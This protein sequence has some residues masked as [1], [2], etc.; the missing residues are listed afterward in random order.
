MGPQPGQRR[1]LRSPQS[2]FE[3][4]ACCRFCR[5]C[6]PRYAQRLGGPQA[7]ALAKG[8][9]FLTGAPPVAAGGGGGWGVNNRCPAGL[10]AA[11]A[12]S[13]SPVGS[14]PMSDH[15]GVSRGFAAAGQ[16][17][18]VGARRTAHPSAARVAPQAVQTPSVSDWLAS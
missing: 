18:I 12:V 15:V 9:S 2:C 17:A 13:C 16:Q 6:T 3:E 14:A 7:A 8:A 4:H 5:P 1:C 11:A 10:G